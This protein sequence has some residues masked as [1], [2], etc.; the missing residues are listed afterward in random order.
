MKSLHGIGHGNVE[1]ISDIKK[2]MSV[3]VLECFS[4]CAASVVV[5]SSFYFKYFSLKL[6]HE[7]LSDGGTKLFV[8]GHSNSGSKQL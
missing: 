4:V 8:T 5:H 7:S 2:N 6:F 1:L 3:N